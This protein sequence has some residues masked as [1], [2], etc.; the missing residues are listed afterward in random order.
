M[1][2]TFWKGLNLTF[3]MLI[4]GILVADFFNSVTAIR[5]TKLLVKKKSNSRL[6]RLREHKKQTVSNEMIQP[7]NKN[8]L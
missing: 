2:V 1:L 4:Q 8:N 6:L 7:K 3:D 5:Y